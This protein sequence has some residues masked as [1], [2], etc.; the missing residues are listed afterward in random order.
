LIINRQR[1]NLAG[2]TARA[3]EFLLSKENLTYI[4]AIGVSDSE[5]EEEEDQ[6]A[7]EL[8]SL[9]QLKK[10]NEN[11][12]ARASVSAEVYGRFNQKSAFQAKVIPKSEEQKERIRKR[13]SQAFMFSALDDK[14]QDIVINAMEEKTYQ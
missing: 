2:S 3:G 8:L 10:K 11:K 14:E 7:G 1:V 5:E 4:K 6:E 13:L 12:G 9:E